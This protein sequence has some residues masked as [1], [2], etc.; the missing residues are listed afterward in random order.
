ME[1]KLAVPALSTRVLTEVELQP[2]KVAKWLAN[3]PLLNVAETSRKLFSTLTVYN[4]IEIDARE[5]LALLELYRPTV[6]DLCAELL[7]QYV[8]LPLPLSDRHKSIAEQARQFQ[9]EMA[10]G[11]K[12]IVQH[13]AAARA[14]TGAPDARELALPIQRAVR[15]L[16]G[17]HAM[18][19]QSY[20]P[21][22]AGTWEEIHALFRH[23]EALG[24]ATVDV[25]DTL[26]NS[27]AHSSV[28]HAYKQALL[29][30]LANPY[31]LP[32]RQI[33]RIHHYLDRYAS[34]AALTP[35]TTTFDPTCQ[36]LI[37]LHGQNAGIV[38]T[39][40]TA[41]DDPGRYR[42]LNTVELARMIHMQW[43]SLQRGELP[44]PDGLEPEFFRDGAQ[45]LL[46]RLANA[47]GLH[48][49]RSFRRTSG[50]EVAVDVVIGIDAINY[51]L[52]GGRRFAVSSSFVGPMP[53]R[54]TLG[55]HEPKVEHE[56]LREYD[57]STW[58]V[59]DEG[60]GGQAL[61]KK[62]LITTRVRVGD[63]VA[64]RRTSNGGAWE[65][66]IIRWVR[67]ASS[68]HAEIGTQRMAPQA[69]ACVVKIVNERN[70]ESD[71]LPALLLPEVSALK[72]PP[73]LVTHR[74]VFRPRREIYM[75]SGYRLYK[76]VITEPVEVT[77]AYERFRFEVLNA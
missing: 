6:R 70:E 22:P 47:W 51:W 30:D 45:E 65:V 58:Q 14:A 52:N 11:Y 44:P 49:R 46:F 61:V 23:A 5:R 20:S 53:Q 9:A 55:L 31:H 35:A 43:T 4:R 25:P 68:S 75:D 10:F 60:A 40:D 16:T 36:F 37:D 32:A 74:G 27:I 72:M 26:N 54:T 56:G 39:G 67:S 66:G 8:G 1:L 41:L 17:V 29:L 33:E 63:I 24:A 64:T 59:M 77:A 38:N 73:S 15:Y 71:F 19:Y 12:R 62:G 76:L 34:L 69:E 48:P 28:A 18:S 2:A 3:L 57:F 42:L 7:R 50:Q 13:Q 21:C